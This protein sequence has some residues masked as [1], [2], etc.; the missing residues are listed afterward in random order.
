MY[1]CS[2]TI[3]QLDKIKIGAKTLD[4]AI[5]KLGDLKKLIQD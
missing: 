3:V 4:D 5:F 2:K 1:K